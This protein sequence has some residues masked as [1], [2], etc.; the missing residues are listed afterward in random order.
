[1]GTSN[2]LTLFAYLLN[3]LG[4][5]FN[6]LIFSLSENSKWKQN[7]SFNTI[8]LHFAGCVLNILHLQLQCLQQSII[9]T[10]FTRVLCDGCVVLMRLL[11]VFTFHR[12]FIFPTRERRKKWHVNFR[13]MVWLWGCSGEDLCQKLVKCDQIGPQ[14]IFSAWPRLPLSAGIIKDNCSSDRVPRP[15]RS[16]T[17]GLRQ[18]PCHCDKCLCGDTQEEKIVLNRYTLKTCVWLVGAIWLIVCIP[19]FENW[20]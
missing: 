9:N 4:Q 13:I 8:L 11:S 5:T 7:G 6:L 16:D 12:T 2:T 20:Y 18:R 17:G 1:M 3:S 14:L 19:C 15:Q 10:N